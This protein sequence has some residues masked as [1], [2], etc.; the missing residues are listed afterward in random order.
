M[1][2]RKKLEVD[3]AECDA[4]QGDEVRASAVGELVRAVGKEIFL[5]FYCWCVLTIQF[6][7]N[8]FS[9]ITTRKW[10]TNFPM[11]KN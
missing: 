10:E 9:L 6:K 1:L 7:S 5:F 11:D 8:L 4:R 2:H 3:E